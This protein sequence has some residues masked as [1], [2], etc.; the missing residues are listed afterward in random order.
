[1]IISVTNSCSLHIVTCVKQKFTDN[2]IQ[3][4]CPEGFFGV[5][6]Q[7]ICNC[8]SGSTCDHITG[9]CTCPPGQMGSL[10]DN[11]CPPGTWGNDCSRQCQCDNDASCDPVSGTCICP[12]G[13]RGARCEESK[14]G[15]GVAFDC[16]VCGGTEIVA[17]GQTITLM[18]LFCCCC[19]CWFLF[20]FFCQSTWDQI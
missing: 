9:E 14:S 7:S 16:T 10:C 12:A 4:A 2:V 20:V 13:Y 6:C 15:A 5:E 11:S 19:C 3:Q 17:A 1:M 18:W 8:G